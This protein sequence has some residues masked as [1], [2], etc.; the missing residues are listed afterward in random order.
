MKATKTHIAAHHNFGDY[1]GVKINDFVCVFCF[2]SFARA[3]LA[4]CLMIS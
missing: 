2:V 3:G 1:L 4:Y